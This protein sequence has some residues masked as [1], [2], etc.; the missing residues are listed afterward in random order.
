MYSNIS[1]HPTLTEVFSTAHGAVFQNDIDRCWQVNFAGKNARFDYR[2][3][4]KLR[5][6]IY[7]IDIEQQLL[8]STQ[9]PDVEIISICACDHC[10]VLSLAQ[11]IALRD[12]LEGTFVMLELN[13]I[14]YDRLYRVPAY[15]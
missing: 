8:D 5:T 9:S 3:L 6:T 1:D 7:R 13:Q 2:C 10:Y 15:I 12:L 11:I 14:I 4:L